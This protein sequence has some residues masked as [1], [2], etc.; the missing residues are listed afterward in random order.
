MASCTVSSRVLSP[1]ANKQFSGA[2]PGGPPGKG[3]HYL[4]FA[5]VSCKGQTRTRPPPSQSAARRSSAY[6][7]GQGLIREAF[8]QPSLAPPSLALHTE[9]RCSPPV[10][11]HP[12]AG[13]GNGDLPGGR[14]EDR[15][16]VIRGAPGLACS[17][18]LLLQCSSPSIPSLQSG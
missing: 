5:V 14:P 4:G 6:P 2:P 11:D 15:N 10:G 12:S 17:S 3:S 18:H 1:K 13:S 16:R 8:Y 9:P 7:S